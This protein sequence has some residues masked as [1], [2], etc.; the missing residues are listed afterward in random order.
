MPALH[1]TIPDR[2]SRALA[3]PRSVTAPLRETPLHARHV[4]LGARMVPFAGWSMP[5]QYRGVIEEHRAVRNSAGV[6]DVSHMGRL[7]VTGEDAPAH[8]QRL[9]SND[10]SALSPGDA[11]YTLLTNETGGIV[12]DL[13]AY[14]RDDGYLLVVNAAN[15][16]MDVEHLRAGLPRVT[17]LAD[18]SDATAML[19]LQGPAS[20]GLLA[21]LADG[22]FDAEA[23]PAFS[24][25]TLEVAGVACTVART[26]YTG[27]PGVEL[28]APAADAERL[29]DALTAAGAAPCGLGARDTLRLEVCYPLHGNDIG[30]S[31][32]AIEAGLGWVCAPER[33]FTGSQ[34][35]RRTR[36]QGPARRL[37]AFRMLERA[38]PRA[39][40]EIVDAEG[41]VVGRVTSGTMSP[42]LGEG[43]G[44]GYVPTPLSAPGT[45][46][47]I[48]VR[49]R[50]CGAETAQKP[51]Y[52]KES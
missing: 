18:D 10:L 15:R 28:I 29:W 9:L 12:D 25:G 37:V 31:T 35:L 5:V 41:S 33:E 30:P 32:N 1:G 20:L 23:A 19:A 4:S 36:L 14:R 17:A 16:E 21:G 52:R 6:F 13:I 48:D 44:M 2:A 45:R 46:I 40:C 7:A 26:G 50:R 39:G 34:V 49:G 38:I 24:W 22:T 8:L 43:I 42:S 27:E 51:L 11:Q 3:Y 47:V